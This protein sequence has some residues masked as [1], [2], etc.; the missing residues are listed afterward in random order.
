MSI[1]EDLIL[2]K[3]REKSFNDLST[4]FSIFPRSI[5]VI[6]PVVSKNRQL[7]GEAIKVPK[8]THKIFQSDRLPSL[9]FVGNESSE[10]KQPATLKLLPANR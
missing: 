2:L 4:V 3:K 5:V 8:Y 9:L 7:S 6:S 1:K 10:P